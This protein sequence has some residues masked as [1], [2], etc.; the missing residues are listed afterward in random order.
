ML[1]FIIGILIFVCLV[2]F[3][4]YMYLKGLYNNLKKRNTETEKYVSYYFN[5]LIQY[6][7][8]L[9]KNNINVQGND[10]NFTQEKPNNYSIDSILDEIADNGIKNVSKDKLDFLRN[11]KDIN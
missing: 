6:R 4:K 8:I 7:D 11:N 3:F 5:I 2:L 9:I 1:F 10:L